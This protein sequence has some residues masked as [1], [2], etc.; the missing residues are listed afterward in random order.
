LSAQIA[1]RLGL[2]SFEVERIRTGGLLHDLGKLGIRDEILNKAGPLTPVEWDRM[3]QHPDLGADMIAEHSA[4][5]HLSPVVRHHHERF[6]GAGYPAGIAGDDIPIGARIIAVAD[7]YDT[8]TGPRVY[9]RES[10][11]PRAAVE[12][13]LQDSAGNRI[14]RARRTPIAQSS[15]LLS[16]A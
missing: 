8:I 2:G 4:L 15:A 6:D 3:K 12:T 1:G 10:L 14:S 9:R 7:A 5:V 16:V 13:R 11:S